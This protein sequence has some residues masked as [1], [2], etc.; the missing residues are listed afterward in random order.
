MA[1]V[2]G[3]RQAWCFATDFEGIGLIC[4]LWG[5]LSQQVREK[6]GKYLGN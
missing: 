6:I 4:R 2:F 1:E 3:P 5:R